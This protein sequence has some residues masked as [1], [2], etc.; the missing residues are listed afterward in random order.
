MSFLAF[1][2]LG[3]LAGFLVLWR[4]LRRAPLLPPGYDADGQ[5]ITR[6][7]SDEKSPAEENHPQPQEARR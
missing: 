7:P 6:T 3:L 5:P 1:I 4:E 2:A